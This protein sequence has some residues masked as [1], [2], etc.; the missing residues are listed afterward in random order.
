M[1]NPR[2]ESI[3]DPQDIADYDKLVGTAPPVQYPFQHQILYRL[4]QKYYR[5]NK[6]N[7]LHPENPRHLTAFF[8][9]VQRTMEELKKQI[10]LKEE[11]DERQNEEKWEAQRL[12]EE[13]PMDRVLREDEIRKNSG[14]ISYRQANSKVPN[15]LRQNYDYS[16]E[17]G[18][19][20]WQ[21]RVKNFEREQETAGGNAS[22]GIQ[23]QKKLHI[24][25]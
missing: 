4:L 6:G 17:L 15:P 10:L 3:Y 25:K 21:N 14:L 18:G 22:C 23:T 13:D 12:L 19:P 8:E 7:Q 16:S 9:M 2:W 11:F 20:E 5:T 1:L 24:D